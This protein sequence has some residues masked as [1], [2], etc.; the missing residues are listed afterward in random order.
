[1][2]GLLFTEFLEF[3]DARFGGACV[4]DLLTA[5]R[6]P[7]GGAYT[8]VE[9]YPA[10]ELYA[11]LAALAERERADPD[12]LLVEYGHHLFGAL[13]DAHP[14]YFANISGTADLMAHVEDHIH[15]EVKKLH[16]DAKPPRFRMEGADGRWTVRYYSH[17]PLHA[18]AHGLMEAAGRHFGEQLTI[19]REIAD[20]AQ[21]LQAVFTLLERANA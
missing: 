16:P 11:M 17:R 5:V 14:D 9:R 10:S 19:E 15:I 4:D 1:M 20:G 18:V 3:V 12:R 2:R 13:H 21:D 6:T 8:A 7:H